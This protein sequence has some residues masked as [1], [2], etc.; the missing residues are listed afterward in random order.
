MI[1]KKIPGVVSVPL[2]RHEDARG[3]LCEMYRLS[4]AKH[5]PALQVNVMRSLA[6][7]LRGSHVHGKHTDYFYLASGEAVFSLYDVRKNSSAYRSGR[8]IPMS[9]G[10]PQ[11][12]IVPPG[13][14]HGV[15]FSVDSV[16]VTVESDYYNPKEE[17]RVK[18]NDQTLG[19]PWPCEA[20]I[21]SPED[22]KA[23][24]FDEMIRNLE[25]YQ[26]KLK[27]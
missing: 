11:A 14:V 4:W 12:L 23:P 24:L 20:P 17:F 9:A 3:W 7:S 10:T 19:M 1:P 6:G 15:Y 22:A 8:L 26:G 13:V 5:V 21:L 2:Q 16:L 18:W 27:V 25:P